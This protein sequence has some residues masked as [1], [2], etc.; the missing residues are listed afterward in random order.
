MFDAPQRRPRRADLRKRCATRGGAHGNSSQVGATP[1]TRC[2]MPGNVGHAGPTYG[3]DA[4]RAA[5]RTAT[6][7]R[8]GLRPRRGV[9]CPATSATRCSMSRNVGHVGPTCGSHAPP[10][11]RISVRRATRRRDGRSVRAGAGWSTPSPGV[12]CCPHSGAGRAAPARAVPRPDAA[13][14][15]R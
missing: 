15:R 2:S 10:S 7:R 8:S 3:S 6:A 1:P 4:P 13:P 9:R 12:R 5:A 11:R 14:G